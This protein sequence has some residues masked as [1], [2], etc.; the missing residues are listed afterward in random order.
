MPP[1]DRSP[2]IGL[3]FPARFDPDA[4]AEDLARTTPT[5]RATAE[6]AR[7]EY[8]HNG[9]PRSQLRPCDDEG[10]DGTSLPGCLKVYL[11]QPAGRFGMVFEVVRTRGKLELEYLAFGIRH[12]PRGSN[13]LTVYELAGARVPAQ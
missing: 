1:S 3:R 4:F 10:R 6:S 8:E 2:E 9:I 12:Q 5:G 11:P 13:A 7:E